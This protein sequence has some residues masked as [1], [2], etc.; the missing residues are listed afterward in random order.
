MNTSSLTTTSTSPKLLLEY[1]GRFRAPLSTELYSRALQSGNPVLL[2]QYIN[3]WVRTIGP[4]EHH[5]DGDFEHFVENM[6]R[7]DAAS[8]AFGYL[9]T[10][11]KHSPSKHL[12]ALCRFIDGSPVLPDDEEHPDFV[13]GPVA[14]WG[15][16]HSHEDDS[17]PADHYWDIPAFRELS[18]RKWTLAG[19]HPDDQNELDLLAVLQSMFDDGIRNFVVKGTAPKSLLVRFTLSVRPTSLYGLDNEIPSEIT[20]AAMHR[21]GDSNVFLVQERIPMVDEYRVFMAGDKPASGAGCIEHYTPLDGRGNAFDVRLEGVRGSGE[22]TEKPELADRMRRFAETA[23]AVLHLQ[24]QKLGAAWVMDLAVNSETGEIVVIELNPARNA[25]LYASS[26]SA[27]MQNV[28]DWLA[29]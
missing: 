29:K 6:A 28:R 1:N 24:A 9:N 16:R 17:N 23:G 26:P 8:R 13:F 21:E 4:M 5:E 12:S 2:A 10:T 14:S 22:I 19:F 15:N 18:G 3:T 27:W 7:F 25:G 20:D 11:I